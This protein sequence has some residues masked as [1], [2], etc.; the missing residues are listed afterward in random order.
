VPNNF[1]TVNGQQI[2]S[3]GQLNSGN[4]GNYLADFAEGI[5]GAFIQQNISPG[6]NLYFWNIAGYAQDHW[7]ILQH[8]SIDYGVRIEH[9]TPWSDAHGVGIPVWNPA[10]YYTD[11]AGSPL[12]GFLWHDIDHSV[13]NSGFSTRWGYVEPRVGFSWDPLKKGKTIVRGGFGIFRAHDSYNDATDGYDNALGVRQLQQYDTTFATVSTA[14]APNSANNVSTTTFHGVTAGDS[15]MPQVK[16][17]DLALVQQLPYKL[18]LQIA[19][20][21]S[22]SNNMLD[23]G[24]DGVVGSLD[25]INALPLNA[26]YSTGQYTVAD[27]SLVQN[28]QGAALDAFRKYPNYSDLDIARHRLSSNYN[29]LQTSLLRQSGHTLFNLNYTFSKALGILG[30]FDNGRPTNPFNLQDDYGP[31]GF[32]RSQVLN[33]SY[34]FQEGSPVHTP[35]ARYFLNDWELSG[36][37]NF[38]SGPS[39][40]SINP[41]FGL[42]GTITGGPNPTTVNATQNYTLSVSPQTF[43]GTPDVTIQPTLLCNPNSHRGNHVYFNAACFGLPTQIGTNGVYRFP[44]IHGPA[45]IE[46]DMTVQKNVSFKD[47]QSVHLRLAAFNFLNHPIASFNSNAGYEDTLAFNYTSNNLTDIPAALGTIPNSNAKTF[48]HADLKTGRRI[49]ELSLKYNF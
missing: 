47:G 39:E 23:N 16:T 5:L 30:Q 40:Q 18:Q 15:E 37:S 25:N 13:P 19:Y 33:A 17:W 48:G 41:N 46:N 6:A 11:Q 38:L 29:G 22:Y 26:L 2:F 12:P 14:K 1:T 20:V 7:R 21:G 32:D 9:I 28:V 43:L 44:Y 8:L 34:T 3:T 49:I 4:G 10:A 27:Y 42:S 35:I 45:Y 24:A 36:I 31:E